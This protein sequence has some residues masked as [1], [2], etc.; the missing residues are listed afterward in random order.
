MNL[1]TSDI[2]LQKDFR[3]KGQFG[4]KVPAPLWLVSQVWAKYNLGFYRWRWRIL[5][6]VLQDK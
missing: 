2:F 5:P 4:I 1:H 3:Y 6:K